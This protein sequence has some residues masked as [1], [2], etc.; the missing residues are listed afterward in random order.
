VRGIWGPVFRV[1]G[2]GKNVLVGTGKADEV[3]L[4]LSQPIVVNVR[5]IVMLVIW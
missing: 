3:I 1:C 2:Y 4:T 5:M